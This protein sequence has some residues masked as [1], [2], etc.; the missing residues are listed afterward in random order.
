MNIL[1]LGHPVPRPWI[2]D[3]GASRLR[4]IEEALSGPGVRLAR[5]HP[6]RLADLEQALVRPCPDLIYSA[7]HHLIDDRGKPINVH[8]FLEERG[9]PFV[10]SDGATLER[11]LSKPALKAE[12]TRAGVPT[13][14]SIHTGMPGVAEEPARAFS[15][16]G[17]SFPCI[18]KPAGGGNSA[19]IDA[20][21]VIWTAEALREAVRR[22]GALHGEL[23]IEEFLGARADLREFTVAMVGPGRRCMPAEIILPRSTGPRLVTTRQK[24][25][26]TARAVAVDDPA[27]R[28]DLIAFAD[29]AF[30]VARVRD[31]ARLDVLRL[32]SGPY[33]LEVNGQPMFPDPWFDACLAYAGFTPEEGIRAA[34]SSALLRTGGD[35]SDRMALWPRASV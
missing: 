23:L 12:W 27:L 29:K 35:P 1:L 20:D 15:D 18:V 11:C 8:G 30:A 28:A 22:I 21:S 24:D 4:R 9:L 3:P 5:C 26:N 19:G 2:V 33:A 17:L 10:G 34:F 6:G 14:R 13:P 7:V 25:E 32:P 31:Y 16:S